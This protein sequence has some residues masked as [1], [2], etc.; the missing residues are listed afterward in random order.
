MTD[1]L[2]RASVQRRLKALDEM[3]EPDDLKVRINEFLWGHLPES[4]TLGDADDLACAIYVI[5][6][7]LRF[8]KTIQEIAQGG[9]H[10]Q[11]DEEGDEARGPGGA[12]LA[13]S[14]PPF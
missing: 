2:K 14:P 4:T 12:A 7:K 5:I 6:G 8:G 9:Q 10:E 13:Q 3:V 1:E 11:A